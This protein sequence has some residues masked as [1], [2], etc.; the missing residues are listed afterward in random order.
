LDSIS[1]AA[2]SAK[3]PGLAKF[4]QVASEVGSRLAQLK[5]ERRGTLIPADANLKQWGIS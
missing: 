3:G 2:T 4:G 5:A 1:L